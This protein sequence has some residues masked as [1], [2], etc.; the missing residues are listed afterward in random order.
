[1]Q[2]GFRD[3]VA[4]ESRHIRDV[5]RYTRPK[6]AEEFRRG[7]A[8]RGDEES[9]AVL[10][11]TGLVMFDKLLHAEEAGSGIDPGPVEDKKMLDQLLVAWGCH[12]G[13]QGSARANCGRAQTLLVILGTHHML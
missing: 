2:H 6:R 13:T 12:P 1:M 4:F 5:A 10:V 11:V 3:E 9:G 7:G 8:D